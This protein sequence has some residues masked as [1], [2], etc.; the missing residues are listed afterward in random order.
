[1]NI[2]VIVFHFPPMSGGGVIVSV[3]IINNLAKLGHKV[4]VIT[5]DV[6]WNGP[7]YEPILESNVNIIRVKVP[8]SDKIKIAARRCRNFLKKEAEKIGN[9]NHFDFIFTIFHP[10]HMASH[11]AVDS[12]KSMNLPV[13]VKIDDAIYQKSKGLKSIQRMIEKIYN[14]RA[15]NKAT[16][17]LVSNEETKII[18][19]EFYK[20]DKNKINIIPNGVDISKFKHIETNSKK[21][22]F[23]GV[24]Y[25]HRGLDV[26]IEAIPLIIKK[27]PKVEVELYG[28][29]PELQ[30]LKN[31]TK[32]K[33]LEYNVKFIDWIPNNKIPEILASGTIGI[34]PLKSTDVTRN[35]LPIKILEYMASSLPIIAVHDTLPKDVLIDGEN[36]FFIKNHTDLASK[37][38]EILSNREKQIVMGQKS[39]EIAKNYDWKIIVKKILNQCP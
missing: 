34:G 17:V 26:L 31:L 4:T 20:V 23:S 13:I 11:A 19:N 36:G 39:L 25:D 37:I 30:K 7:L 28:E 22:I 1:M 3:E 38:I 35:A 29:G 18:V 12:G 21:I 24:M 10:F 2:L 14:S 8:S 6:K 27:I 32:Q 15:L 33:N 5:P 9:K 16:S